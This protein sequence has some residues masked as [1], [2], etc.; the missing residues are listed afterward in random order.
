MNSAA[1][2]NIY[3]NFNTILLD[4]DLNIADDYITDNTKAIWQ[5][6]NKM[7]EQ[8]NSTRKWTQ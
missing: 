6:V 1:Y 2:K 3:Q 4:G 8:M 5:K 7:E